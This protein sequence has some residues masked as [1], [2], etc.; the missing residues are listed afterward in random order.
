MQDQHTLNARARE[1]AARADTELNRVYG[2]LTKAWG[3]KSASLAALKKSQ[4]AWLAFRD[5][6]VVLHTK[7]FSDGSG[8][9]QVAKGTLARLTHERTRGLLLFLAGPGVLGDGK[10]LSAADAQLNKIWNEE[11]AVQ[12]TELESAARTAQRAWLVFR[13][14]EVALWKLLGGSGSAAQA[15]LTW[16]RCEG[17][18]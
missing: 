9:E 12:A 6:E 15:R 17:L 11:S 4:V 16:E 5:A 3:G 2:R 10:D 1:S 13:D 18:V 8:A 7:E 14:A